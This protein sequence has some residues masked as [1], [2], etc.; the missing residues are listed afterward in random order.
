MSCFPDKKTF[1]E[2]A[3]I[4]NLIPVWR[5]WLADQETPVSAYER[6]R[7]EFRKQ[8]ENPFTFLLESVEGG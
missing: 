8:R 1:I 6:I 3:K 4:G 5:E 2:K 7:A